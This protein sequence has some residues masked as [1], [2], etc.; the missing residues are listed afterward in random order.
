MTKPVQLLTRVRY[1]CRCSQLLLTNQRY[2]HPRP[3]AYLRTFLKS[4]ITFSIPPQI[5]DFLFGFRLIK[6]LSIPVTSSLL[7]QVPTH[8]DIRYSHRFQCMSLFVLRVHSLSLILYI[9]LATM[10]YIK[11]LTSACRIMF[12]IVFELSYITATFVSAV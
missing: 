7:L 10:L 8:R 12:C 4:L 1:T 6:T 5:V 11:Y 9:F 3:D 2:P